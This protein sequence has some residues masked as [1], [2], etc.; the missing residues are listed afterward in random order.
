MNCLAVEADDGIV[1]VDCGV[2]FPQTDLGID[3]F[4]PDFSYLEERRS[5]IAG[6]VITHG[7]EDHIGGLPY[8]LRCADVPVWAPAHAMNLA[9]ERL[10]ERGFELRQLKLNTIVPRTR[11][12]I[13]PLSVEPVRVTHS[14]LEACALILRTPAGTIVHTGDFKF[15]PTPP[16]GEHM[17]VERLKQVGDEGVRLLLSDSTNIDAPASSGSEKL[18]GE[19]ID[20]LV[21][22]APARVIVGLFSSNVQRLIMLGEIAQ[23]HRRRICLLGRSANTHVRIATQME[24]LGWPSDLLVPSESVQAVPRSSLLVLASGTQA[25]PVAAMWRMATRSHPA[26]AL[27]PGDRVILSS[28][29]IPGNDP[30]V[31]RM[32]GHLLRQGVEV[33]SRITDPEVHVSGHAHRDEQRRMLELVRPQSFVPVHGTL[34][35]LHRHAQFARSLGQ[36]DV[37]VA[38]NGDVVEV[39]AGPLRKIDEVAVGKVATYDGEEISDD[40]LRERES[41]GRTGIAVVTLVVDVRG[42]L[43]SPPLLS[44]RG[45][46]DAG[47]DKDLMRGAAL[48]IAQALSGRPFASERPTDEQIIEVAQRAVRRNLDG[49]S[50]RRPVAV[51][52]VV[53]P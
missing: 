11:Y 29:I 34:H 1:V 26:L 49:I 48:E 51:V 30:A 31:L 36:P 52:H 40:V 43:L 41:L 21:Q 35:H 28:R 47:E 22:D 16:D 27:D 37:L 2:T 10:V 38:E 6:V 7:H 24:R 20:K 53:R 3:V 39:G 15:D 50:G 19:A 46:L 44:T 5:R 42:Q 13:G 12:K 18:V 33:R 14:I 17:D 8:L 45:V 9:K 4:H 32:I 23:R 25:E